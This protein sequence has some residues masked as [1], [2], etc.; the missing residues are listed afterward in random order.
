[1]HFVVTETLQAPPGGVFDVISDPRRRME[2]QSSLRS[3]D[4]STSGPPRQGMRWREVTQGW[5]SFDMEITKFERP[6]LWSERGHGWLADA[7]LE[8]VFEPVGAA[9]RVSVAVDIAFKGPFRALA[10]LVRR[11][12]P[13]ALAADLRRVAALARQVDRGQPV[14]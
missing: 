4:V 1:V 12:M 9:T 6:A 7:T 2:W 13:G 3:V 11:F 8:V 5:V 10:P 14:G